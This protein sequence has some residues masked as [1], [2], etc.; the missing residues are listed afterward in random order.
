[1]FS[2][3]SRFDSPFHGKKNVLWQ[4]CSH[5][6]TSLA[7]PPQSPTPCSCDITCTYYHKNGHYHDGCWKC[8]FDKQ[9]A[10]EHDSHFAKEEGE[11]SDSESINENFHLHF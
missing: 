9:K 11:C 7:Y 4:A 5:T 6:P 8:A 1:M 10:E 2:Q 3:N